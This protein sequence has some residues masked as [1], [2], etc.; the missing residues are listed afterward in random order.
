MIA[1]NAQQEPNQTKLIILNANL[2]FAMQDKKT[3]L[4]EQRPPQELQCAQNAFSA[5]I[6]QMVKQ[7]TK[8]V[9]LKNVR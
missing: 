9:K 4:I 1:W 3:L 2:Q 6:Q 5:S 8:N 7:R